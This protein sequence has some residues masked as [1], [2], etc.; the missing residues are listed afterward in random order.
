MLTT[1]AHP[2]APQEISAWTKWVRE[3]VSLHR[4]WDQ[5]ALS[6]EFAVKGT[7]K[8]AFVEKAL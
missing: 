1:I 2:P 6:W 5:I 3:G 4:F 7:N 8:E